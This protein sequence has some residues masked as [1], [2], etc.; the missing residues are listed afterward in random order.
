VPSVLGDPKAGT[1]QITEEI[2]SDNEKLNHVTKQVAGTAHGKTVW[3]TS[4][5][6]RTADYPIVGE[7]SL[8][9]GGIR[10]TQTEWQDPA[11]V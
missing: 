9:S 4:E 3:V 5:G 2:S 1:F 11:R 7:F 8:V 10:V 6:G